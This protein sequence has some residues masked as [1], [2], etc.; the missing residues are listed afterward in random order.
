MY[1]N[2]IFLFIAPFIPGA[3]GIG[4]IVVRPFEIILLLSISQVN[5]SR[6]TILRN[7]VVSLLLLFTVVQLLTVTKSGI[8][9]VIS[10]TLQNLEILFYVSLLF[11]WFQKAKSKERLIQNVITIVF[12]YLVVIVLYHSYNGSTIRYKMINE[13]KTLFGIFFLLAIELRKKRSLLLVLGF[14]FLI[15]SLERKAW[16]GALFAT[17]LIDGRV[18]YL[19]K[20]KTILLLG[21][22]FSL[23]AIVYQQVELIRDQIDSLVSAFGDTDS[24]DQTN[25]NLSRLF[26]YDFALESFLSNPILG[27]GVNNFKEYIDAFALKLDE[28]SHG[29]HNE[30]LRVLVEHGLLGCSV[31]LAL[32]ITV[33]KKLKSIRSRYIWL[34]R[35]IVYGI[36]VNLFLGAGLLNKIYFFVY[37]ALMLEILKYDEIHT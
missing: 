25:S 21:V 4:G 34:S 24:G 14:I 26:I 2:F 35:L 33:Y 28:K 29:S 22:I 1:N 16:I 9:E 19:F 6:L 7:R 15:F 12:A 17:L 8:N 30:Y 32:L 23:I 31:I 37:P 20:A 13:V 18:K 27:I 5:W 11:Y 3:L 10:E 36:V